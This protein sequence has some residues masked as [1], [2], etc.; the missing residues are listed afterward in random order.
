MTHK[1][2]LSPP[3]DTFSLFMM[4]VRPW[5]FLDRENYWRWSL[6][7]SSIKCHNNSVWVPPRKPPDPVKDFY[8]SK[9]YDLKTRVDI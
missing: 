7:T 5:I 3:T 2:S 8:G 6:S 9:T 1:E 4:S